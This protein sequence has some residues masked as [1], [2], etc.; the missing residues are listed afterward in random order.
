MPAVHDFETDCRQFAIRSLPL[1]ARRQDLT[2]DV[3]AYR[4]I[5]PVRRDLSTDILER[6]RHVGES[7]LVELQH[8][9]HVGAVGS[10]PIRGRERLPLRGRNP[11][12]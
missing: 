8:R 5:V 11:Y 6:R 1:L 4:L 10:G 12:L 3:F 2:G 9:D 7:G